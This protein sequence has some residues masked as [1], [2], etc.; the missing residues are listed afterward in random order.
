MCAEKTRLLVLIADRGEVAANDL[1]VGIL[2]DVVLR[3]LEHAEVEVGDGAER[4][5]GDEDYGLFL[6][7]PEHAGEAVGRERV[8]W[9]V[10]E[11]GCRWGW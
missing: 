8:V 4:A 6:G 1:P 9:R 3:H 7:V 5:A 2:A 11:A 10:R